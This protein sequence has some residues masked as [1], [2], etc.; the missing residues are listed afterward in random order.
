MKGFFLKKRKILLFLIILLIYGFPVFSLSGK[1]LY[2]Y[3]NSFNR[4]YITSSTEITD[5]LD[6]CS[7]AEL[8]Y[9]NSKINKMIQGSLKTFFTTHE[10]KYFEIIKK[11]SQKYKIPS[12]LIAA[13]IKCESSFNPSAR[14]SSGAV[15]LMQL[16]KRTAQLMGVKNLY[17]PEDNIFGG[18]KYLK[19]LFEKFNNDL[20]LVLAAYNAGP[21]NVSK[22][23]GVP[24]FE[25][26][27]RYI[28]KVLFYKQYYDD[29]QMFVKDKQYSLEKCIS[30]FKKKDYENALACSLKAVKENSPFP[31][32]YH[33]T[34]LLY[35][36]KNAYGL[37]EKYYLMALGLDPYFYNSAWNLAVLYEKRKKYN[38]AHNVLCKFVKACPEKYS[39]SHVNDYIKYLEQFKNFNTSIEKS[40]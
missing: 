21:G 18:T 2:F 11:A 29:G 35:D 37:A 6:E 24:P 7:N 3:K 15:G 28:E 1:K 22:F 20:R 39:H 38:L 10:Q 34:A 8:I 5:N 36:L 32:L 12:T 17:D 14:S 26:T 4:L 23:N 25:Q 30:F 9:F 33:N 13:V 27:K 31:G 40:F 19:M 16:M